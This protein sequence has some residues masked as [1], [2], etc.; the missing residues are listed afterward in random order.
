MNKKIRIS[1]LGVAMCLL[2]RLAGAQSGC[3]DSPENPTALL[4]LIGAT[5]SAVPWLVRKIA[6][7]SRR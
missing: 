6:K 4:A 1:L 2:V 3:V 7:K 5:G